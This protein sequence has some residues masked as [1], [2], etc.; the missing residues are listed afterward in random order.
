[1]KQF[2]LAVCLALFAASTMAVPVPEYHFTTDI[3][4]ALSPKSITHIEASSANLYWHFVSGS[5][6]VDLAGSPSVAFMFGPSDRTFKQTVAGSVSSAAD[7]AVLIPLTPTAT[8]TNGNFAFDLRVTDGVN[9]LCRSFGTMEL[10]PRAG[11]EGLPFPTGQNID[12]A[13]VAFTNEPWAAKG[14]TG[15]G[16]IGTDLVARA[17]GTFST[18]WITTNDYSSAIQ[19]NK[20]AVAALSNAGFLTEEHDPDFALWQNNGFEGVVSIEDD[21]LYSA[22]VADGMP[23]VVA[24]ETDPGFYGWIAAGHPGVV[25]VESDPAFTSF[26]STNKIVRSDGVRNIEP[27]TQAAF[28]ALAVKDANTYYVITQ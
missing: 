26:A 7:G 22:W 9:V 25:E 27:I 14:S 6:A 10:I 23:G 16:T 3:T 21:P 5:N 15:G 4:K 24:V 13:G 11:G 19:S 12:L 1:M 2:A 8:A 17:D 20:Q 18:N 28:D